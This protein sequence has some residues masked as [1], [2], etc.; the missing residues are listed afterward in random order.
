LRVLGNRL[1]KRIFGYMREVVIGGW[2]NEELYDLK[3][4][5]SPHIIRMIRSK[6]PYG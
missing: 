6:A 3:A 5:S 1:L 4:Y 2:R